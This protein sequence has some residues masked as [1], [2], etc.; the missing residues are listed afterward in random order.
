MSNQMLDLH[1]FKSMFKEFAKSELQS[2]QSSC[3]SWQDCYYIQYPLELKNSD[4]EA[5][6]WAVKSKLQVALIGPMQ[7]KEA[8]TQQLPQLQKTI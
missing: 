3:Y 5:V 7:A 6:T 2:K 1:G 8:K 4:D